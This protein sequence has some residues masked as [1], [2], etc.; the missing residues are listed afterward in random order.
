MIQLAQSQAFIKEWFHS[1]L[2]NQINPNT[3]YLNKLR[4]T[5]HKINQPCPT[6]HNHIELSLTSLSLFPDFDN[7]KAP[8]LVMYNLWP[9]HDQVITIHYQAV[10]KSWP[11]YGQLTGKSSQT[12]K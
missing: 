6:S 10:A 9:S 2:P 3:L 5:S 7:I 12:L 1:G 11:R 8:L 4:T